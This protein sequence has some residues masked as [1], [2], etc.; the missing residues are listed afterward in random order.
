MQ[1]ALLQQLGL[2]NEQAN[3]RRARQSEAQQA[4]LDEC[5]LTIGQARLNL[6]IAETQRRL[7]S[8]ELERSVE[9]QNLEVQLKRLEQQ[10]VQRD[11]DYEGR[12]TSDGDFDATTDKLRDLDHDT[13]EYKVTYS[14]EIT[15]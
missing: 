10:R 14:A 8:E 13:A 11:V 15:N 9:L 12:S 5:K 2:S 6:R 7:R 3:L 1:K 4:A